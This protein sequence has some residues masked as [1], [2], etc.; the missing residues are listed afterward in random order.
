[1][2]TLELLPEA[3]REIEGLPDRERR[4]VENA[5]DKLRVLGGT[6]GYAHSSHV[7]G[8]RLRELRPRRGASPW[9]VFYVEHARGMIIVLGV[10]SEALRDRRAFDRAIRAAEQRLTEWDP[11]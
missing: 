6:L 8:S 10:G 5:L 2:V 3:T 1:M 7:Q 9:R 11:R 4:A